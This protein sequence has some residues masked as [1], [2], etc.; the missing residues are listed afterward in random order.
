MHREPIMKTFKEYL[1]ESK[2][3]YNFRIKVADNDF[4]KDRETALENSLARFA[5]SSF[6]KTGKTPIQQ[7]PLDFPQIKNTEVNIYE[8]NLDYPT[9]QFELKE[10]LASELKITRDHI[11]VRSPDEPY[12][13]YQQ[14]TEKREG[15]LLL[16]SEYKEAPNVNPED[17]YGDKYNSG[18]VQELNAILKLQRKERGE[19]IPEASDT[20]T[21][22]TAKAKFNTDAP[23][24]NKSPV[25]QAADLRKK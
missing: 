2:K 11:V 23:Q 15:A 9:T 19:V 6:K 4:G 14:E 5:I 20:N 12:E 7:L 17:Y 10:Y 25:V 13:Q 3:T 22:A 8:I 21:G 16:D 1:S 18:F 24:N